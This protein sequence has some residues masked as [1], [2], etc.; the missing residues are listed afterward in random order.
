[1]AISINRP[2]CMIRTLV[3]GS[4]HH[5]RTMT[6]IHRRSLYICMPMLHLCPMGPASQIFTYPECVQYGIV[7]RLRE[8]KST[9]ANCQMQFR[10]SSGWGW[11][12]NIQPKHQALTIWPLH[13]IDH[14]WNGC[15]VEK[16][17][18][19]RRHQKR[20]R[21]RN[22]ISLSSSHWMSSAFAYVEWMCEKSHDT[23]TSHIWW[24]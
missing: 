7:R 1:M 14:H 9:F 17:E 3:P 18:K 16:I 4:R 13:A 15:H 20:K 5:R 10:W 11:A 6:G 24:W 12:T 8:E 19:K 23:S 22:Y 21:S 2:Y